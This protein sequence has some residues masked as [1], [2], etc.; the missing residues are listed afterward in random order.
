MDLHTHKGATHTYTRKYKLSH[1]HT[2]TLNTICNNKIMMGK[3]ELYSE[4]YTKDQ[5][6]SQFLKVILI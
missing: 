6:N 5:N 1:T 4:K 3:G 2:Y